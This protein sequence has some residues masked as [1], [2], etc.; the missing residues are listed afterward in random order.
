MYDQQEVD[1]QK[2]RPIQM[3][4]FLR[5]Y[6]SRRLLAL[7]EG[8]ISALT[9]AVRQL[10]VGSQGGAE[11]LAIFHQL[12]LDEW[13][14][15]A[16]TEP[17]ARI[18][19]DEKNCFGMIERRAVH[20][21]AARLLPSHTAAAWKHRNFCHVQQDGLPDN[22]P[23]VSC[24]FCV[25]PHYYHHVSTSF[26]HPVCSVFLCFSVLYPPFPLFSSPALLCPLQH[27]HAH[28]TD[29]THNTQY[30]CWVLILGVMAF[31][32]KPSWSEAVWLGCL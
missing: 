3:G 24:V 1:P 26:V 10:G 5:K 14:A 29:S 31:L 23:N 30:T 12:L 16:L 15:G 17:L 28:T 9:A 18:K 11:A 21:A 22:C 27:S 20:E 13:A 2:V 8:E 25:C 19:V 32:A 7:N 6:V 4:E